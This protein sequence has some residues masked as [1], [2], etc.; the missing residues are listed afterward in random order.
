MNRITESSFTRRR[1]F[2]VGAGLIAVLAV[3]SALR[4]AEKKPVVV[5]WSEGTAPKN[6]YPNDINGAIAEGLKRDLPG[7][8]VVVAGLDQPQQ[9]LPDELLNRA[10]VLVWWGHQHH[11]RVDDELVKKVVDRVK[12]GGMGFLSLH[13][14]HFAK[15]NKALMGTPC[16]WGA[17]KGDSTRATL[18]VKAPDH[19]IAEGLPK[20]FSFAHGERY[21][22]PYAAPTPETVVFDGGHTLKDGGF[23]P[24]R[25]GMC[26][27]IGKG[28]VFYFQPGHETNP[29]FMDENVR[30]IMANAAKWAA[31]TQT[32]AAAKR[33]PF[34]PRMDLPEVRAELS[35]LLDACGVARPTTPPKVLVFWKCE[36]FAHA[37]AIEHAIAFYQLAAQKGY[38][39]AEF[40][41]DYAAL[42]PANLAKYDALVMNNTTSLDLKAHAGLERTLLDY[43]RGGKGYV[44]LHGAADNFRD[45]PALCELLGGCFAGHPWTWRGGDWKFKIDAPDSPINATLGKAPFFFGD[46]IYQHR[47]PYGDRKKIR[48][49]V[50]LDFSDP[51][52]AEMNAKSQCHR[53]TN[54]YPVSWT[55]KEGAG[56]VF[57][58]SFGHDRAAYAHPKILPH[59]LLGTLYATGNVQ[60]E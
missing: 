33:P 49:L 42:Q 24:A 6:V 32:S 20:E 54:D 7:W 45:S 34:T 60:A 58:T 9:G 43:V 50:S 4:A 39:Q 28:R 21:S 3:P 12:N 40:A 37:Q 8:E 25:Q 30:K 36:G 16:S 18:V 53:D 38:L 27:T 52:T 57:Y 15:M 17:Y 47:T 13:S 46:E 19:P 35:P 44:A 51:K 1:L 11:A 2:G 41:G 31:P 5:V 10:D 14:S 23:D 48:V 26:W 22:E 56:R 59:I 29:V 55:R